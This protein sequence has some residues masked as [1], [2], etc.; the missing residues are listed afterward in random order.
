MQQ[1]GTVAGNIAK[2]LKSSNSS[3][4]LSIFKYLPLGE[5]LTLGITDGAISSLGALGRRVVYAVRMPTLTQQA[6]AL[7]TAG[8]V[9]TGKLFSSFFNDEQ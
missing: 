7:L 2:Y 8:A 6:K 1:A 4:G 3:D 9:T 5:M